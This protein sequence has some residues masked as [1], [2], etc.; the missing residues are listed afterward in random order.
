[1]DSLYDNVAVIV[2]KRHGIRSL[3]LLCCMLS[4]IAPALRNIM[5]VRMY[6]WA[7]CFVFLAFLCFEGILLY[8]KRD[9]HIAC[10]F[11]TL[12]TTYT[13]SYA[14][15]CVA[16]LYLTLLIYGFFGNKKLSNNSDKGSSNT[17]QLGSQ[18]TENKSKVYSI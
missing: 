2:R 14:L 7:A 5:E 11:V 1:M 16:F 13:H 4:T 17:L 6:E 15:L 8:R 18:D 3:I 12:L 10:L 9:D